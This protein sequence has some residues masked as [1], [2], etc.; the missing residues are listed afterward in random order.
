VQL[1]A[2]VEHQREA[3]VDEREAVF[4]CDAGHGSS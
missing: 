1:L 2:V 3:V 4:D